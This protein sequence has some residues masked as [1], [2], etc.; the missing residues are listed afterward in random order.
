MGAWPTCAWPTRFL[1]P[2]LGTESNHE[3]RRHDVCRGKTMAV[4]RPG[5]RRRRK[6]LLAASLTLL[7]GGLALGAWLLWRGGPVPAALPGPR[8]TYPS[9]YR[10][11]SPAVA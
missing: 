7:L 2:S 4:S 6:Y 1:H 11:V 3:R 8:V 5:T 10:P 9:P